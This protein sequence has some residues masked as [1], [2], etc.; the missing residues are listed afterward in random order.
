MEFYKTINLIPKDDL[1][2]K[3]NELV[4]DYGYNFCSLKRDKINKEDL[5]L[6]PRNTVNK[7]FIKG[8]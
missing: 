3:N 8:I 4:N 2:R 7:D 1:E 6:K 5:Y